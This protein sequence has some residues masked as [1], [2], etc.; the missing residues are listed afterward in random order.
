MAEDFRP[1]GI[2]SVSLY[3][4]LVLTEGVTV[5]LQY[6]AHETNRETP[7]FVGRTVAALAADP[8]KLR[9]TGRWLV[10]AELAEVYGID[11]EFGHRPHSNR[12]AIL[13]DP[14]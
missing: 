5:N 10:A 3:P 2:T 1:H 8:D 6:F 14:N 11:D 9:Y 12:A 4:G 7:L 13:G